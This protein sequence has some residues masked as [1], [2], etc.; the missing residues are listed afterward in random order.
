[1]NIFSLHDW[2]EFGYNEWKNLAGTAENSKQRTGELSEAFPA[3][4]TRSEDITLV[5][6]FIFIHK[7]LLWTSFTLKRT[8]LC[9]IY[10]LWQRK[11]NGVCSFCPF[12]PER[13]RDEGDLIRTEMETWQSSIPEAIPVVS[14]NF[15]PT[16]SAPHH[17]LNRSPPEPHQRA[18]C[19]QRHDWQLVR[20][21]PQ[22]I[23]ASRRPLPG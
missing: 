11:K 10:Y 4:G 18:G 1:M 9:Y 2:V 6:N 19:Y 15:P 21:M 8:G 23:F 3:S 13:R 7:H 20:D 17:H 16:Q 22:L 5:C 14:L 12:S